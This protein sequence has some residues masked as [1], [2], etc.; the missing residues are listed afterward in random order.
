[1]INFTYIWI[2]IVKM[3][4]QR[5][6]IP[7]IK[8]H[9]W[10]IKNFPTDLMDENTMGSQ[11]QEPEQPMQSIDTIM[12]IISEATIPAAGSAALNHFLSDSL[13]MDEDID[14]LSDSE[15]DIDSSG[16]I[17]YAMWWILY[18]L[19]LGMMEFSSYP[20][21]LTI[22]GVLVVARLTYWNGFSNL[23]L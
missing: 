20:I 5:I 10:F 7:E 6:T 19:H 9:E 15:I 21:L 23:S 12:Q 3:W 17:V 2:T 22:T 18:S 8:K 11:F 4:I 16:E 13:D 14:D 1:M